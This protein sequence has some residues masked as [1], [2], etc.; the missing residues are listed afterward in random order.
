MAKLQ[1]SRAPSTVGKG[2][3]HPS[4]RA[5]SQ[6]AGGV[7]VLACEE[8]QGGGAAVLKGCLL[9][10]LVDMGGCCR[11]PVCTETERSTH[12]MDVFGI[13]CLESDLGCCTKYLP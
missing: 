13:F 1:V 7:P 4:M 9:Q 12:W 3:R 10:P 5:S 2:T 6:G 8:E 11:A